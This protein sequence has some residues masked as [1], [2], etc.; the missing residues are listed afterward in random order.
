MSTLHLVLAL[1]AL[2]R[3]GELLYAARNTR[4]L[5]ARGAVEI[6]R[7]HYPL[8]ILLHGAWLL[9]LVVFVPGDS[10]VHWPMLALFVGLQAMRIWVIATLGPYW[11]TRIIMPI[12]APLITHGP[13]RYLRHPN[14]LVATIE[15]AVL[16]LAFGA[17]RIAAIFLMLKVLLLAWRIKVESEALDARRAV[18]ADGVI[19]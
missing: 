6:G 9:S 10:S 18:G 14:Y 12:D 1:V 3:L 15:I 8:F 11:T 4:R 17:V 2:Q 5:K 13:Y 16:P 7:A 19:G